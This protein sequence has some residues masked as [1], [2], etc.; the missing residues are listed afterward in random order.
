MTRLSK[1]YLDKIVPAMVEKFSYKNKLQVPYIEKIV[2]NMGIGEAAT[3]VKILETAMNELAVITGQRPVIR[4]AK[5]AIANFKIREGQPVGCKV[6]LRSH[7]MY[8]FFDR[9]INIT[10]P[11]IRDFRGIPGESFD[12][13]GNYAFGLTEQTIFPE[14]DYDKIKRNQGMDIIIVT[15]AKSKEESYE[16]LRLFGMPFRKRMEK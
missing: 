1:V 9:L 10:L 8:E 6:T 2:I 13:Q 3:D 16:L 7:H 4:R 14:I 11:R 12:G 5:K 15:T